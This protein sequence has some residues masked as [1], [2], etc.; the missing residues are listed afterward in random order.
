MRVIITGGTG[1]IGTVLVEALA[2]RGA[3]VIVLS[4]DPVVATQR[5]H[6]LGL[7]RVQTVG[8]DARTAAGWGQLISSTCA[9]VNLAGAS[10]AHW[11]WTTAYRRRIVESR[12]R[13]GAAI[14]QAIQRHGP[15]SVL[16]QASAAGYYGDRGQEVL[17]ELSAP[18]WGFRADVC[19]AWEASI[20]H[21]ETR[22]C[23]LRT[24]IVLDAHAGAFPVL[25]R[26]AELFGGR[27]GTGRQWMPWMHIHDVASAICFLVD[28]PSLFGAFNLC[29]PDL[30]TNEEFLRQVRRALKRRGLFPIPTLALRALLG[31]LSTAV[32]DSQRVLPRRLCEA[33][34]QFA[35]PHLA[36]ALH[37]LLG[38]RGGRR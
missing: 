13:A 10:P 1:L 26:F 25:R 19:Q 21:A 8:W 33:N 17:T 6:T 31:E 12:L 16:V 37:Q 30:V 9:I 2:Q 20:A 7:P 24:G 15:P 38:R 34:F 5:F 18:G 23:V 29:A 27:L 36:Q 35:F 32:L 11:R 14:I 3:E 28:Q 22:T 4:R